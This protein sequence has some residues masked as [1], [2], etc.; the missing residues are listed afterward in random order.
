LRQ[1]PE[2]LLQRMDRNRRRELRAHERLST[3]IITDRARLT[4]FLSENYCAFADRISLPAGERWTQATLQAYCS[5][6][7]T[8]LLGMEGSEGIL[9]AHLYAHTSHAAEFV[10]QVAGPD[11]RQHTTP[12]IWHAVRLLQAMG[13]P[14][15]NLGGGV[16]EGD[17]I[18]QAKQ[19]LG[20]DRYGL[21]A[22]RQVY[23]PDSYALLCKR[24]GQNPEAPGYFPAYRRAGSAG[25]T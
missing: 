5:A 12:L 3:G 14:L 17:A 6:P 2:R 16:S 9:A 8:F 21:A 25:D 23:D 4:R 19:R 11:G 24:A 7:A 15:L 13:V 10:L 22:L 1:P 20:A 18:A